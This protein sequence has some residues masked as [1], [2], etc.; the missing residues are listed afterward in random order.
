MAFIAFGKETLEVHI[1]R[2]YLPRVG[3]VDFNSEL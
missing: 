3:F 1:N 2:P